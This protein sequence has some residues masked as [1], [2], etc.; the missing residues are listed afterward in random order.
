MRASTQAGE[1]NGECITHN[2]GNKQTKQK[3][4][5]QVSHD[6]WHEEG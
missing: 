5:E 4:R 1:T 3:T 2:R 6:P